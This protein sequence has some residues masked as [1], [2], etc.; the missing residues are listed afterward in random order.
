MSEQITA[1]YE[2]P[3]AEELTTLG[4]EAATAAGASG[5]F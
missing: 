5:P 3:Q 4:D 1:P 2:A